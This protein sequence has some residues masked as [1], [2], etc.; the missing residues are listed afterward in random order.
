[1]EENMNYPTV[2]ADTVA[3]HYKVPAAAIRCYVEALAGLEIIADVNYAVDSASIVLYA[4]SVG[5]DDKII[6]STIADTIPAHAAPGY[7]GRHRR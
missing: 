2:Y 5:V 4:A 6:D 3:N 1:M 7:R